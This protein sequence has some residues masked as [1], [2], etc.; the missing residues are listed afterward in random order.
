M[1]ESLGAARLDIEVD[2]T[3]LEAAISK[4]K[5]RLADMSTDAQKQYSQLGSSEK[6]R[7]D[8]LV[9]QA[10]TLNMTRAQQ[11]AYNAALKTSGP[12]LDDLTRKIAQNEARLKGSA[13]QFNAFGNSVKQNAM[14]MRQ[15]P[16]QMTD[17]FV[18][19]ATG[20]KPMM[21]L[22]QQGGQ[23]KD[24]FGGIVPA[25]KALGGALMGLVNPY[26]V[27][28]GAAAAAA[29]AMSDGQRQ[30]FEFEKAILMTGNAA[31]VTVGQL[32]NMAGRL[33]DFSG[34]QRSAAR[35]LTQM[36]STGKIASSEMENV[37]RAVTRLQSVAGIPI[38]DT[39]RNM[40]ALGEKPAEASRKLNEQYRYL[41]AAAL[42]RI[43]ALEDEGRASEAAAMAQR[44]F[45]DAG[46]A[47]ADELER[48][49]GVLPKLAR[50]AGSAFAEMWDGLMGL[51][52]AKTP[53]EMLA[54]I[55]RRL[56]GGLRGGFAVDAGGGFDLGPSAIER[57]L[58][59]QQRDRMIEESRWDSLAAENAANVLRQNEALSSA[60]ER[61]AKIEEAN[62]TRR[63]KL[64][65]EIAEVRKAGLE[66]GKAEVDIERQ[67]SRVRERYKEAPKTNADD[68][69]AKSLL[70]SIERQ[71][72]ANNLLAATGDKATA[73]D[74]L[75]ARARQMLAE[76]TNSMTDAT[77]MLLHAMLP[78]LEAS[79]LAAQAAERERK[80]KEALAR[81]NT[82]LQQQTD[83]RR[84]SNNATIMAFGSGQDGIEQFQR[85][86]AINREYEA[87][88]GRLGDR[89]VAD[90]QATWDAMADNAAAHRDQMMREEAEFQRQRAA[91][92][93]DP[94]NGAQAAWEDYLASAQNAAGMTYD[95]FSDAFKGAEDAIVKFALT[96]K[97]SFKDMA[98]DIIANLA[99]IAAK[100]MI[101][102]L[103]N[104][105]PGGFGGF[106]QSLLKPERNALGGVYS[107]PG[108]SAYSGKV[109]SSPTI[110][111]FAKGAGLMG[112]AGPEAIMPLKRTQGG[113]LGVV[114]TGAGGVVNVHIHGAPT[115]PQIGKRRNAN[116][117]LDI[118][119]LFKQNEA[120]MAERVA[121][122]ASLLNRALN[123]RYDIRTR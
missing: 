77:R 12:V 19:L 92:M 96:G 43:R 112:E 110:F 72:E 41:N 111:P 7:I 82:M 38:E 107:S 71:I 1:S 53:D 91:A 106:M 113:Q 20:Q 98:D 44:E 40:V 93:A 2:V 69:S 120:W 87:E 21:V 75:S 48:H 49:L 31:G 39:I 115:Q 13:I 42:E 73:S 70:E 51:G 6:R 58:L 18:G 90:D 108:L 102:G 104:T 114:A 57:R 37:A 88:L 4:A 26:T 100:Q 14:A 15:V 116:G 3:Q 55:E 56:A 50:G 47:R 81:Q 121:G 35:V 17:I 76:Q 34:T 66:A 10:D 9:Q 94:L 74:N 29:Y 83:N 67:I 54:D 63:E 122:G 25:A 8:R 97:L 80:A 85:R 109:V 123:S 62:L 32:A 59:E 64:E 28:A 118:D 24:L 78:S 68:N 101:T 89:A 103:I 65:R 33:D 45:A 86:I 30:A 36:T 52:R 23:L 22:L 105:I 5:S 11:L 117:G 84:D 79:E 27:V 46:L 95:L 99:R 60:R 16:M 61:W 119:V